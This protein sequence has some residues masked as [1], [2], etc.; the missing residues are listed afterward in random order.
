MLL[1]DQRSREEQGYLY[2]ISLTYKDYKL[3]FIPEQLHSHNLN[4]CN[5]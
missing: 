5:G 4:H 3:L 1:E 2:L